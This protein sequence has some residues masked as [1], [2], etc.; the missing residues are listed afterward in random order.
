MNSNRYYKEEK[1]KSRKQGPRVYTYQNKDISSIQQQIVVDLS[2][3]SYSQPQTLYDDDSIYTFCQSQNKKQ[4]K[5]F[6]TQSVSISVE[7]SLDNNLQLKGYQN[8]FQSS[9]SIKVSSSN[10]QPK[11]N[12]NKGKQENKKN[13]N[14]KKCT[15]LKSI[16][17]PLSEQQDKSASISSISFSNSIKFEPNR[18]KF[19]SSV[20]SID[21]SNKRLTRS[22]SQNQNQIIFNNIFS[23]MQHIKDKM[24]QQN[25]SSNTSSR[26]A[27]KNITKAVG[28]QN[29]NKSQNS[30]LNCS[31]ITDSDICQIE[32]T[33]YKKKGY[34]NSQESSVEASKTNFLVGA[35]STTQPKQRKNE[36]NY[37]QENELDDDEEDDE[38]YYLRQTAKAYD[39]RKA[40]ENRFVFADEKDYKNLQNQK[41]FDENSKP[42]FKI[43]KKSNNIFNDKACLKN[44]TKD[45]S[46]INQGTRKADSAQTSVTQCKEQ[47][48][49]NQQSK[50]F[51][52]HQNGTKKGL[53]KA[54]FFFFDE[55][56]DLRFSNKL[57]SLKSQDETHLNID[58]QN[59]WNKNSCLN[60][61]SSEKNQYKQNNNK[62]DFFNIKQLNNQNIWNQDHVNE[63]EQIDLNQ[64]FQKRI[65][66][67][68]QNN[69]CFG[70]DSAFTIDYEKL[71]YTSQ[72]SNRIRHYE[73]N[74]FKDKD[75]RI[76][77][78]FQ[79][80]IQELTLDDDN[81]TDDETLDYYVEVC[82]NDLLVGIE[83]NKS[84]SQEFYGESESNSSSSNSQNSSKKMDPLWRYFRPPNH[85]EIVE[86]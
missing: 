56:E 69:Q 74:C 60:H 57:S 58:D 79:K 81:Q 23:G 14:L 72:N 78:K 49:R 16:V 53:D 66:N 44:E 6:S 31:T 15:S 43:V 64:M 54:P 33:K 40:N 26:M 86:A 38:L 4:A 8:S 52:K 70:V 76:D 35:A 47:L 18:N 29:L 83:M 36:K 71:R 75:L 34:N 24:I 61:N 22:A 59:I 1:S 12:K 2:Q 39:N 65:K 62:L 5:H 21:S 55:D 85:S 80:K 28:V 67:S 82:F 25:I 32:K 51:E 41:M 77:Q 68:Q 13:N 63:T 27:K 48:E 46:Y 42:S 30:I 3:S 45:S 7:N 37:S 9:V 19:Q 10:N 17:D 84:E 11:P 73:F 20:D 50:L